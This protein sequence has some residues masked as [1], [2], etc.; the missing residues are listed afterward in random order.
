[1]FEIRRFPASQTR[2]RLALVVLVVSTFALAAQVQARWKAEYASQPPDV[3]QWYRNAELTEA[4]QARFRFKKCCDHAD[5]GEDQ[6]QRQPDD[7][8]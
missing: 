1:M 7:G 6:V 5:R 2:G 4:A 8:R 3:Q